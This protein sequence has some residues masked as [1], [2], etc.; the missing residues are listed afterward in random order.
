MSAPAPQP[1]FLLNIHANTR[2]ISDSPENPPPESHE[3][4]ETWTFQITRWIQGRI[5]ALT[6]TPSSR[7]PW[8]LTTWPTSHAQNLWSSYWLHLI[9]KMNCLNRFVSQLC[10]AKHWFVC[11]H[12]LPCIPY[13]VFEFLV[14]NPLPVF[15][16][17]DFACDS[18]ILL[19]LGNILPDPVFE[20]R[21]LFWYPATWWILI[22]LWAAHAF[23]LSLFLNLTLCLFW[24]WAIIYRNECST[25]LS[26]RDWYPQKTSIHQ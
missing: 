5:M 3:P 6:L 23:C 26:R 13:F 10:F 22:K 15:T 9:D 7:R 18:D 2:T 21:L 16:F 20:Y 14:L 24:L 4:E 8:S 17:P 1:H 19:V 12:S 11:V 25:I